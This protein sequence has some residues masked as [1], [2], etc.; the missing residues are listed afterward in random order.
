MWLLCR[1]KSYRIR[2]VLFVIFVPVIITAFVWNVENRDFVSKKEESITLTGWFTI[3]WGDSK[4]GSEA[5]KTIYLL[6]DSNGKS[7]RLLLSESLIKSLGGVLSHNHQFVSVTGMLVPSSLDQS[8]TPVLEVTSLSIDTSEMEDMGLN[9][10][11]VNGSRPFV[12]I[13]CKFS[14]VSSEPKDHNYF[15][16]MYSGAYPGLDHYWRELS[17]NTVN[18]VGSNAFGW[19]QL[20]HPKSY[21]VS[22]ELNHDRAAE[23]CTA[24]ADND[25]N[26]KNYYGINLMFNS[27][28]DGYAWGGGRYM[29]LDGVT[30]VWPMTWEPPWGY[31]NITVM[32]HEMGH[33]FGLPHSS[34]NYGKVYD[35][36][37]DVMSSSWSF[38]YL[39]EDPNYG[40]LGQHTITFHKDYLGWIPASQKIVVDALNSSSLLALSGSEKYLM[41]QIPIDGSY[42]HFYTVEVRQLNGY[43]VKLPG[44]AVVIHEVDTTRECPA[45]VI[46]MDINGDTSDDGAMWSVGET[47]DD[48]SSNIS[49]TVLDSSDNGYKVRVN[50]KS[51]SATFWLLSN[52]FSS[53]FMDVTPFHWAYNFIEDLYRSSI[54]AGCGGQP[55]LYCPDKSVTRAQMALF[56]ER[57][58]HGTNYS[59]PAASGIFDDVPTTYWAA[60]WIEQLY[61]DGITSGCGNGN[62]CPDNS[63]TRAQ[64]ALFLLR[65]MH[66][67]DYSPP[68]A[69]GIFDD[70]PTSYWA[71]SWIEQLYNEGIT[72]GCGGGNFCPNASVTRAQ[73]AVFLTRAFEL[74]MP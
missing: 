49:V 52:A 4:P 64:M 50:N 18:L 17:Y 37:W 24:V 10:F 61:H 73:M 33:A 54:T 66:G 6:T 35:N 13:M 11:A 41:A 25:V 55:P 2:L 45:H 16:E 40:C 27:E 48:A 53:I 47:F 22:G 63:V 56:L 32:S 70:V 31:E 30:K 21:Y 57:G 12:S 42:S 43:D 29:K 72:S 7:T 69:S 68:P 15:L 67:E 26:F 3:I 60:S 74:P 59:P 23:D 38:C 1:K 65:S 36:V 19:Y 39:T 5:A 58:I 44:S 28:L 51:Q 62:Y 8:D 20:P 71:A 9:A 34:G 14:D 46:D